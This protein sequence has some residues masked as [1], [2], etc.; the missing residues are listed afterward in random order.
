MRKDP[1][2]NKRGAGR[3]AG[4]AGRAAGFTLVEVIIAI[5]A[6]AVVSVGLAAIFQTVGKTVTQ[7][8]KVSALTQYAATLEQQMRRDFASM[9]REGF[10]VVRNQFAGPRNGGANWVVGIN[11]DDSNPRFRRVD[12]LLFFTKGQFETGRAPVNPLVVA[13]GDS[14]MVYYGH[15]LKPVHRDTNGD[16]KPDPRD[17]RPSV[18]SLNDPNPNRAADTPPGRQEL[19]AFAGGGTFGESLG[20]GFA[21]PNTYAEDWSLLRLLERSRHRHRRVSAAARHRS[22]LVVES[23]AVAM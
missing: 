15:G 12:E 5:G 7:G 23:A 2:T 22:V 21:L 6:V 9:T 19:F 14:A 13:R 1:G 4:L 16:G 3:L 8:Q 10:L 11:K 17:V 18:S 20:G